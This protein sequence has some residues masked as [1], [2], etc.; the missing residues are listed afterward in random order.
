[1]VYDDDKIVGLSFVAIII[2]IKRRCDH[3]FNSLR[4]PMTTPVRI[5]CVP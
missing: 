4:P 3:R 2:Q 1:M 5:P